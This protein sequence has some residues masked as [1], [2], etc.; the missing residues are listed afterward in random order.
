MANLHSGGLPMF[1]PCRTDLR[2]TSEYTIYISPCL[3]SMWVGTWMVKTF[4]SRMDPKNHNNN[5]KKK[6]KKNRTRNQLDTD[7][8][9][10]QS[11]SPFPRFLLIEST[12]PD[13]PLS[14]LS[15]VSIQKRFN[16]SVAGSPKSVKNCL[17]AHC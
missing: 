9:T 13:R 11:T 7:S 17:L 15:S 12:V 6:K 16:F 2:M 3:T 8:E 4:I 10:T 5:N 1:Y 14:K